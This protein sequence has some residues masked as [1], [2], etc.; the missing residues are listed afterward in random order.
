MKFSALS[1]MI[2]CCQAA[3]TLLGGDAF[4]IS[5]SSIRRGAALSEGRGDAVH[6]ATMDQLER[7]LEGPVVELRGGKTTGSKKASAGK[8][9]KSL[10]SKG[11]SSKSSKSNKK[12]SKKPSFF[13]TVK[14]FF[15]SLVDPHFALKLQAKK[16]KH[17]TVH[18]S[19]ST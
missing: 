6:A 3:G 5:E 4:V 13:A 8:S 16:E 14:A 1:L 9:S 17:N 10:S 7:I 18:G 12:E 2:V 11:K 15:K 19:G